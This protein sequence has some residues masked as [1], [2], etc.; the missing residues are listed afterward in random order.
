VSGN[1]CF[2][3]TESDVG[4]H[5]G[6]RIDV[7]QRT[8]CTDVVRRPGSRISRCWKRINDRNRGACGLQL[9]RQ[10]GACQWILL[11]QCGSLKAAIAPIPG[12]AGAEGSGSSW[13]WRSGLQAANG[14]LSLDS[15][16][17]RCGSAWWRSQVDMPSAPSWRKC[18]Q[19]S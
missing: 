5:A 11:D 2:V 3:W 4:E 14:P 7:L 8:Q 6:T 16:T 10:Q 9:G 13:V 12:G 17:A 1:P 15:R 19:V 18:S